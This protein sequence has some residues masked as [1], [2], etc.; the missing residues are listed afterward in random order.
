MKQLLLYILLFCLLGCE[1]AASDANSSYGSGKGGSLAR[2]TIAGNYLYTVDET[3]LKVFDVSNPAAPVFQRTIPVGFEI[4]TIFPFNGRLFIGSTSVV[5]IF[6]LDDPAH[7]K[8]LSEAVSPEVLRR[9]DP[10]VAK[11]TVAFATLRTNGPCGGMASILA[12]YDIRNIEK[13]VQRA[14]YPVSE[15]YGLGYEGNTLYVCDKQQ[16]LMV[17]DISNAYEPQF[18]KSVNDGEYVDVI[19]YGDVLLC[20]VQAGMILYDISDNQNPSLLTQIN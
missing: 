6:S 17:F 18:L 8:K 11:D 9:C 16:G 10:V 5:H 1:K 4:E 3:H 15:P 20:W 13:P 7:P 19:P 12:V 14:S 2:F